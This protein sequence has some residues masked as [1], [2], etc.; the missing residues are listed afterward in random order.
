MNETTIT[1][2]AYGN[3]SNKLVKNTS[4]TSTTNLNAA[5]CLFSPSDANLTSKKLL[6]LHDAVGAFQGH[7]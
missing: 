3:K 1:Q 5:L 6:T 2:G 4:N 7:V